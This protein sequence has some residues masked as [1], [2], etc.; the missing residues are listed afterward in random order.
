MLEYVNDCLCINHNAESALHKLWFFP[1]K[2][3]SIGDP[4]VYLGAKL[5]KIQLS[6]GVFAWELFPSKY[7]QQ[8]IANIE[9]HLTEQGK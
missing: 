2:K 7:V 1:M 8:A 4:D 6:N 5:Q 3:G 9:L